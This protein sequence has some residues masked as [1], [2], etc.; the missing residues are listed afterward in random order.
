[1]TVFCTTCSAE[2]DEAAPLLPALE[3]YQ[4]ALIAKVHEESKRNGVG[5]L[6][7]SGQYGLISPDEPIP[8]YDHLLR[9]EEVSAHAR[10]CARQLA[11]S[12]VT[13]VLFHIPPLHSDPNLQPYLDTLRDACLM[14]CVA[15]SVVEMSID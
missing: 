6:I 2:K 5:F 14:A 11:E 7:L 12:N 1:M 15:F 13:E 3:R 4:S 9:P 8:Y 10:L